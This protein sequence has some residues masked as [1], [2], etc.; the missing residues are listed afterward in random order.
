MALAGVGPGAPRTRRAIVGEVT[1]YGVSEQDLASQVPGTT[2]GS[3]G[4]KHPR[5]QNQ[6]EIRVLH[7]DDAPEV[8]QANFVERKGQFDADGCNCKRA[9]TQASGRKGTET[10]LS[11]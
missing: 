8:F 9:V 5:C 10:V 7:D 1:A 2:R 11:K 6:G 4:A 3:K